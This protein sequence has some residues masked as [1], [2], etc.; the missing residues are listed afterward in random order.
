MEAGFRPVIFDN[1]CN[2]SQEVLDGIARITGKTPDFILGDV[3]SHDDLISLFNRYDIDAV[4][5]F[6]ALKAVGE[7]SEKPLE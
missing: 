7:S 1:L 3:T 5:H 6:A 2:S 4:I